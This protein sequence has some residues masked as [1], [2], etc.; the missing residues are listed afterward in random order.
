MLVKYYRPV[1]L[2]PVFGKM[3]E[4]LIYNSIFN[5]FQSNKLFTPFQSGFLP[6]G[7]CIAQLLS[8][9]HEIQTVFDD[10][11]TVYIKNL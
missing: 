7:S 11:T 1:S 10:N 5:Y 3:F 8:I 2:L 9:S 6:G 4:R